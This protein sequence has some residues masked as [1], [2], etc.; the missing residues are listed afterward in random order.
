MSYTTSDIQ[1]A[2]E[3]QVNY[4]ELARILELDLN[5][6]AGQVIEEPENTITFKVF[7]D[8]GEFET[9]IS[10]SLPGEGEGFLITPVLL[11]FINGNYS[12]MRGP[13]FFSTV[14]SIEVVGYEKDRENLRKIFETYSYMNQG[15]IDKDE[16]G[17]YITKTLEFP[18]FDEPFQLKGETRFQGFM[19]LFLN[20][21]YSG[22]LANQITTTIDGDSVILQNLVIRRQRTPDAAQRN[23]ETEVKVIHKNQILSFSASMLYDGS[24]AAKKILRNIK[25]FGS[26]L[27]EEFTLEITYPNITTLSD[28]VWEEISLTDPADITLFGVEGTPEELFGSANSY[29]EGT[30]CRIEY[31]SIMPEFYRYFITTERVESVDTDTYT[32]VVDGGEIT[33]MEGG[34]LSL[35]FA[36]VLA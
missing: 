31:P 27:N 11:K 24:D 17:I 15:I 32:V 20:Y 19:R 6:I 26:G 29:D 10:D 9:C 18:F 3:K 22:Q 36:L 23:G 30:I 1:E 8:S 25:N 13:K 28:S 21:M 35:T 14:F 16:L 34:V 33:V 2:L 7:F 12:T 4:E 5:N